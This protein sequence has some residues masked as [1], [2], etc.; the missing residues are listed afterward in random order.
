MESF[1]GLAAYIWTGYCAIS[2]I[3]IEAKKR[4]EGLSFKEQKIGYIFQ[5]IIYW[6]FTS[7]ILNMLIT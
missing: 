7:L 1:I 4:N 5:I 3:Q 2:H 6:I